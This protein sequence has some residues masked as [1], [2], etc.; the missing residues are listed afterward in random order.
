M[1][2]VVYVIHFE[3]K[4]YHAQHYIGWAKVLEPRIKRHRQGQGS[5][6]LAHLNKIGIA[7]EVVFTK[8]GTGDDERAMKNRHKSSHF[9]PKCKKKKTV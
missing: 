8:P 5:R 3:R 9:C 4:Y 2:G 6:L 1:M 7:W